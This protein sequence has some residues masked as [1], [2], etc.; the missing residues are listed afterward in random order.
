MTPIQTRK[1]NA[2]FRKLKGYV[3]T[4][5]PQILSDDPDVSGTDDYDDLQDKP[6]IE[7][8]T[9]VQGM[10]LQD[11]NVHSITNLEIDAICQ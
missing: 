3:T 4:I 9:L 8:A 1:L 11:I 2:N 10:Q 7:G 5:Q 6:S